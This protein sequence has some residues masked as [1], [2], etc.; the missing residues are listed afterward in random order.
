[1]GFPGGQEVAM[2]ILISAGEVSGD[3]H[4]A[5]VVRAIKARAPGAH[6][7]GMAGKLCA[8][9]GALLDVDCY[10]AG[11][12][13]GFFELFRS[14][15]K[16]LS[17]FK[18]LSKLCSTWK[19]D[20]LIVVDYPDFNMRLA[21]VAK[22]HG[23]RVLYFIPPKV[24]A[25]RSGR[26]RAIRRS[27]DQIAAIFPF[28]PEFYLRH[29]FS[30]A[31]YVGH[32]LSERV[33]HGLQPQQRDN[34]ILL[35]PGSR[36]FEVER[37]L[38]PMLLGFELLQKRYPDLRPAVVLAPNI[39][40]EW[41]RGVIADRVRPEVLNSVEWSHE[42]ALTAMQRARVG[43]LKSGTCNLE[44]AIAGLP[45]VC[46]YSG[47]KLSK[48]IISTFVALSEYSPVNII[49]PHTVKELMQT[50]LSPDDV[51][52][53]VERVLIEGDARN[54]MLEGLAAVRRALCD[55][56]EEWQPEWRNITVS[57]RVAQCVFNLLPAPI[58]GGNHPLELNSEGRVTVGESD[59]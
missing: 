4:L 31:M 56:Q 22:R 44:G 5:R 2:K 14:G 8:Q 57:E 42:D 25:W 50:T 58:L 12:G 6:I 30:N 16:I 38:V 7:R 32:P 37:L 13:M 52:R 26:V 29:G 35:L 9:A 48:V 21:K 24:W 11:A 45:F 34:T 49:R 55:A 41:V 17:S 54:A 33:Q 19:P 40:A 1:M 53:E 46:V 28:E 23:V 27:V 43:I 3:Q 20:L 51:A 36:R 10:R 39:S 18:T 47:T 59:V 15:G